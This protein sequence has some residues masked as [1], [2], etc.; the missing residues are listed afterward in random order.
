MRRFW[1]LTAPL[2]CLAQS[3]YG[4]T[5]GLPDEKLI[6]QAR[7]VMEQLYALHHNQAERTARA[8]IAQAPDEPLGYT[9]LARSLWSR[10]MSN[11]NA[12]NVRRFTQ[13]PLDRGWEHQASTMPP[14]REAEFHQASQAAVRLSRNRLKA[15]GADRS[16]LFALG[17]TYLNLGAFHYAVRAETWPAFR[18]GEQAVQ[19]HRRLMELDPELAEPHLVNG[20][21]LYLADVLSWKVKWIAVLLG[22][23]R[24][25]EAGKQE[26]SLA[27]RSGT[28][29]ADD[30]RSLLIVLHQRDGE[31]SEAVLL[32]EEF[33][34]R[35]PTN[36]LVDLELA[37][38]QLRL[39][40]FAEAQRRYRRIFAKAA[41]RRDG[42]E[43]V[44]RVGLLNS[45]G[46]VERELG[47]P[48]RALAYLEAAAHQP[49]RTAAQETVT[50]IETG[51]TL[52]LLGRRSEAKAHYLVAEK[53]NDVFGSR[54]EALWLLS[55]PYSLGR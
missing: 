38:L 16:A 50:H 28:L 18:N 44:D 32:L 14:D 19:I 48:E 5:A 49:A 41:G 22:F 42:Y 3:V 26:L 51:K 29:T 34:A 27:M 55:R 8:M 4:P 23:P 52:D 10:V 36:Y 24:G 45:L 39:G 25:R 40:Q 21:A 33:A 12:L 43:R 17:L 35:Y 2:A 1:M 15:N 54:E 31:F 37:G 13:T 30:A 9:M 47:H 46:V 20:L 53:R 6:V 11:E 7:L